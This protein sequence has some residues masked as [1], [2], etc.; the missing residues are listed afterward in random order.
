M[1]AV[2]HAS[3]AASLW[4]GNDVHFLTAFNDGVLRTA[5]AWQ[6]CAGNTQHVYFATQEALYHYDGSTWRSYRLPNR[7]DVRAVYLSDDGREVYVGGINIY[8]KFNAAENGE[9]KF[10]RLGGNAR[11]L[12]NSWGIFHSDGAL[13][14]QGDY[15]VG[16]LRGDKLTYI[17]AGGPVRSSAM[18]NGLFFATT[19]DGLKMLMGNRLV[20]AP[21][22]EA[23]RGKNLRRLASDGKRMLV[24][25]QSDGAYLYDGAVLERI[26]AADPVYARMGTMFSGAVHGNRVA[27]GSVENG[28]AVI[29]LKDGTTEHYH[30]A[31]GLPNNTVLSLAFDGRGDLWAGL[32]QGLA[33]VHLSM[34]ATTLSNRLSHIGSGYT[35]LVTGGRLLAGTNRGLFERVGGE[36]R[37]AGIF[38]QQVW[39]LGDV[40]GRTLCGADNGL[41]DIT[42]GQ[43]ARVG[44]LSG[45]WEVQPMLGNA[46]RALVGT[47]SGLFVIERSAGGWRTAGNIAG[48]EGSFANFVQLPGNRLL[49]AES[50]RGITLI[51]YDPARMRLSRYSVIDHAAGEDLK[52]SAV[53]SKTGSTVWL[54]TA[55]KILRWDNARSTFTED[56][57]ILSGLKPR[58]RLLRFEQAH[59][60][61]W[62]LTDQE[63]IR[64]TTGPDGKPDRVR[65][66]SVLPQPYRPMYSGRIL[67]IVSPECASL[68]TYDGYTTLHFGPEAE[69]EADFKRVLISEVSVTGSCDSLLFVSNAANL[70]PQPRLAPSLN[71]L[72][73]VYGNAHDVLKGNVLYRL[74]MDKDE[75][76]AWSPAISKEFSN[77]E[78]GSHIFSVEA[79]Y[80]TGDTA[81]DSFEFTVLP[82]WWRSVWAKTV[83]I[84]LAIML[85]GLAL[86]LERRHQMRRQTHALAA[87]EQEIRETRNEMERQRVLKDQEIENIE[88]KRVDETARHKALEMA[89]ALTLLASKNQ[90]LIDINKELTDVHSRIHSA[91]ERKAILAIKSHIDTSMRTDEVL[92]RVEDEFDIVHNGFLKAL[93]DRFPDLSVQER[94]MCAYLKM[95]LSTK[96]IAPILNLSE[97]GAESMRFRIRKKMGLDRYGNMSKFLNEVE[98]GLVDE[99][100]K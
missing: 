12:G 80:A 76:S 9:M 32:D 14:I 63:L 20:N 58:G 100:G 5:K 69:T 4:N 15:A 57:T 38:G 71:S 23:L 94:R 46:D 60:F 55:G 30:E 10:E 83:Y 70:R 24:V 51:S 90:I 26:A 72:R 89:N 73:F 85:L 45:V 21:G 42:S 56:R 49:M 66:V 8:G 19:D 67:S 40:L 87:K 59:G 62:L 88:Q 50:T 93:R 68:A 18:L 98:K 47:Y 7:A 22:A 79:R 39:F 81:Q 33:K 65:S 86:W 82:P 2:W 34:P 25:T 48:A 77:I 3:A 43:P 95:N 64:F 54:T 37:P 53:L 17:E 96:E 16:V 35:A 91:E 29:N 84:L 27:L 99:D 28:L 52:T 92:K 61:F 41:F 44:S 11:D 6:I 75:W 13:F 31:N 1:A 74:R 97:R 78:P 36:F